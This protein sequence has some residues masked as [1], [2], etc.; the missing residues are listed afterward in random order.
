M[1]LRLDRG[2]GFRSFFSGVDQRP[3]H[4]GDV[5]HSEQAGVAGDRQVTEMPG[6]HDLGRVMDACRGG[7]G[8]RGRV[9]I[10][11]SAQT[12][13]TFLP[14]AMA[15]A[16]SAS[17]MMPGHLSGLRIHDHESCRAGV[18]HQVRGRSHVVVLA[19][20]GQRCPHDVCDGGRGRSRMKRRFLCGDACHN[21]LHF[22]PPELPD[23]DHVVLGGRGRVRPA[24]A[25]RVLVAGGPAGGGVTGPRRL[26]AAA[27]CR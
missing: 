10:T 6:R 11:A 9:V 27:V 21:L 1:L 24:F 5:S 2:T 15:W 17:V 8:R 25:S 3:A 18:F 26:A 14:S 22:R 20:R 4:V 19:D 16:T 13:L 23:G 7:E 12:S